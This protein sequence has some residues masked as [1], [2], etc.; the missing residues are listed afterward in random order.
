VVIPDRVHHGPDPVKDWS[1]L[2]G[3]DGLRQANVLVAA[4]H[5]DKCLSPSLVVRICSFLEFII[6]FVP[7]FDFK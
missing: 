1:D 3:R 4:S 7:L 5:Q 6:R 2:V